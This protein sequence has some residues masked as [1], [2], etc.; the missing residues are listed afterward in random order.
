MFQPMYPVATDFGRKLVNGKLVATIM[1][2]EAMPAEFERYKY[3]R[4]K[5]GMCARGCSC[6]RASVRFFIAC[7][8][9]G[10]H[11]KCSTIELTLEDSDS[12]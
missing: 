8:C 10:D 9:T 11:K 7:L 3:C 5:K 1:L 12:D 2:K 6:A 4:C